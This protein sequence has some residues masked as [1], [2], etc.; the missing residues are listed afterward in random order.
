MKK[1]GRERVWV[2]FVSPSKSRVTFV[3]CAAPSFLSYTDSLGF[4]SF[5]SEI[6]LSKAASYPTSH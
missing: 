6:C 2:S 4:W 5:Y 3:L 1:L